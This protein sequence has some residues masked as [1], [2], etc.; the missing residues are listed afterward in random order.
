MNEN[1]EQSLTLWQRRRRIL[2]AALIC[3]LCLLSFFV[4]TKKEGFYID[5]LWSYGLANSY[6][7][8]HLQDK[9]SYLNDWHAPSFY[10]DYLKVTDRAEAFAYDSVRSNQAADV[11][12]P[13]Y[14]VLLHSICSFMPGAW[15]KWTGLFMN[16]FFGFCVLYLMYRIMLLL[17][18]DIMPLIAVTG[19]GVSAAAF[20]QVLY[21][22]MY[23]MLTCFVLL[24]LYLTLRMMRESAGG[25]MRL[26]ICM[27]FAVL[28]GFL[29]HYY[30]LIFLFFLTSTATVI[31][32]LRK[33][34]ATAGCWL[35]SHALAGGLGLLLFPAAFT[36]IFR[37]EKGRESL[38][39]LSQ[40][41]RMMLGKVKSF[42][43][44][45]AGELFGIRSGVALLI[46]ALLVIAAVLCG[47]RLQGDRIEMPILILPTLCFFVTVSVIA[48]DDADRYLFAIYPCICMCFYT[49]IFVIGRKKRMV[50]LALTGLMLG[51]QAG[52]SLFGDRINYIYPGYEAARQRLATEYT[53]APGIYITK[54]DHLVI[55]NILFLSALERTIAV[56]ERQEEEIPEI[57]ADGGFA[58]VDTLVLFVDIYFDEEETA[59]QVASLI[60]LG[61]IE[62][63]YD[64]TFTQIYLLRKTS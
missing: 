59:K 51:L 9:A 10:T 44:L 52:S 58:D 21:I 53:D 63:V 38:S 26:H 5:E 16:L 29:T 47:R 64:N 14:Y 35:L 13:L 24:V 30:F 27:F 42:G 19:Y 60:G 34:F 49:L 17:C 31:F 48:T 1:R 33:R 61:E 3:F 55:N 28:A 20:S 54:G 46:V 4:C 40:G 7:M 32:L 23:Q 45:A 2:T 12:P 25:G 36:Q 18:G 15:S 6:Y 50:S 41:G 39:A 43:D 62:K 8:P 22:R 11:H 37:G 56:E 57:L